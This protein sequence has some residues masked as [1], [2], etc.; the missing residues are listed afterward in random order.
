[1]KNKLEVEVGEGGRKQIEAGM[2]IGME[3]EVEEEADMCG[4]TDVNRR[5]EENHGRLRARKFLWWK[6]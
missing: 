6:C 4:V 2:I 1:M 5:R 3:V